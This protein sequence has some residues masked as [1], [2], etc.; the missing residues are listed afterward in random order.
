MLHDTYK[1]RQAEQSN[2]RNE[3][4]SVAPEDVDEDVATGDVGEDVFARRHVHDLWV[5]DVAKKSSE[6]TTCITYQC[7]KTAVLSCHRCLINTGVE[8]TNNI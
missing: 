2:G 3:S 1:M 5:N 4:E 8:K 7:R 6:R